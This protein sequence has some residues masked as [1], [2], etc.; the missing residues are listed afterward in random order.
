MLDS[1]WI[2]IVVY[3]LS[4]SF[5]FLLLSLYM[6]KNSN[7]V[8]SSFAQCVIE[9]VFEYMTHTHTH[10]S[11]CDLN[12]WRNWIQLMT[13]QKRNKNDVLFHNS[14][15]F[16]YCMRMFTCI[17]FF[18]FCTT[19]VL[20]CSKQ[21]VSSVEHS[22]KDETKRSTIYAYILDFTTTHLCDSLCSSQFNW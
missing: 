4:I 7:F 1:S 13:K 21:E 9:T 15:E 10:P 5:V 14:I 11:H 8:S 16:I 22:T 3:F 17:F 20:T 12:I 18:F 2:I 6:A 19:S